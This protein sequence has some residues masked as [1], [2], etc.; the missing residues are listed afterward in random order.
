[1]N[2]L[3]QSELSKLKKDE[4][5]ALLLANSAQ[6][7]NEMSE[8]NADEYIEIMSGVPWKLNLNRGI[9]RNP[10]RFKTMFQTKRVMYKD[11]V[12]VLEL[13][14]RFAEEGIFIILDE[15][16]IRKHGL[17]EAYEAILNENLFKAVLSEPFDVAL[18]IFKL[19]NS[20]QKA[21]IANVMISKMADGE[22]IDMNFIHAITAETGIQ[23]LE[24]V[25]D[26]RALAEIT[27]Q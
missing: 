5:I 7:G 3:T 23:V 12:E 26:K 11:L 6:S 9:G 18:P 14:Q 15:R 22:E 17:E 25:K 8:I 13:N 16:V 2:T 27:S 10:F 24:K 1:M 21:I 20:R 19:A 4:L